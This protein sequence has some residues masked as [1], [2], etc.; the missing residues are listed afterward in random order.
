MLVGSG[1]GVGVADGVADAVGAGAVSPCPRDGAPGPEK[2]PIV[3]HCRSAREALARLFVEE[4]AGETGGVLHCFSEDP[5]F[6]RFCLDQGF[7]VSFSGII[8]FPKAEA[9][10]EAARSVPLDRLL[11]ETDAPFLAPVPF[12]GR[13]NE[14]SLVAEVTRAIARLRNELE[15]TVAAATSANFDRLFSRA[16]S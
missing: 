3:V 10:R 15:E 11:V 14:P 6:A 12:R 2:L 13:R 8:T 16:A 5:P 9:I 4:R 7:Y 1:E